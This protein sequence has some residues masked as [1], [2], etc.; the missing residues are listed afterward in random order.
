MSRRSTVAFFCAICLTV[1]GVAYAASFTLTSQQLGAGTV[2]TPLM[3]PDSVS[4]TNA[5]ANVGKIEKNDTITFVW[6]RVI[7][8]PTLCSGWANSGSTHTV[9]MTWTIQ[10][11]AGAT[12][13]DVLMPGTIATCTAGLD[14]GSVD[15]G[16]PLYVGSNGSSGSNPTTLTVGATTTTLTMKWA[17]TPSGSPVKV[18][19]GSAGTWTPDLSVQDMSGNNC[20]SNVAKTGETNLF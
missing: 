10:N 7:N 11:N 13:N 15:L 9:N 1:A 4:T 5:G 12:G 16:S 14:V 8:Q 2:T 18:T 17:N 20:G 19:N 6:S 3:F